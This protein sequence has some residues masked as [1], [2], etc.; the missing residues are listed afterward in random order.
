MGLPAWNKGKKMPP[1]KEE[2]KKKLSEAHKGKKLSEETKQKIREINRGSAWGFK[3]GD[4]H[5]SWKG[6][7]SFE[8]YGIKFNEELKE[9]IRKRDNYRCQECGIRQDELI[10]HNK[11]LDTHHIDYDKRN[12]I[13][14]NL[15]SLCNSCHA[16]TGF[17]REDWII[18]FNQRA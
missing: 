2:T 12:N 8:P 16:Q 15:I 5:P 4:K 6:G 7:K 3:K 11:K 13:P 10:G 9:Q 18:Y 1:K 17:K 14:E